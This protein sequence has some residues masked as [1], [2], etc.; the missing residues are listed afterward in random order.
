MTKCVIT[1]TK[2]LLL[3]ILKERL[4]NLGQADEDWQSF[5]EATADLINTA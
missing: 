5:L 2:P 1:A 4:V 3:S